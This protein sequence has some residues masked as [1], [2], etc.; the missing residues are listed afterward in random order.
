MHIEKCFYP[1]GQGAFYSETHRTDSGENIVIVYDCGS[2]NLSDLEREIDNFGF[3]KIDYLVI[4]HFHRDHINGIP[5]L[6]KKGIQIK[7]VFIPKLTNSEKALYFIE[8]PE[9]KAVY[10]PEN[11]FGTDQIIEVDNT[12][13]PQEPVDPNGNFSHPLGHATPLVVNKKTDW[14]LKFYVDKA[15]FS[16]LSIKEQAT[17]D[18]FDEKC[19]DD[20]K[21][22]A[23]I[24][25]IYSK[26]SGNFNN[27]SMSM[28]SGPS[29]Y[30]LAIP[31]LAYC[32]RGI[33]LNGDANFSAPGK[34]DKFVQHY[35]DQKNLVS[36]FG[37]PHHGSHHNMRQPLTDFSYTQAVIQSGYLSKHGH[38]AHS[39]IN[40]HES[41]GISVQIITEKSDAW[42][43]PANNPSSN[44]ID[45][46]V[47][48][49]LASKSFAEANF[50]T[51]SL[52]ARVSCLTPNQI[53]GLI[54]N[55]SKNSQVYLSFKL[56][57]LLDALHDEL[58]HTNRELERFM[59]QI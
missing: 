33:L 51:E 44:S 5:S 36:V 1:I 10:N 22:K 41:A 53:R 25:K 20:S 31:F 23:A 29:K 57:G 59:S 28:Y 13:D 52:I 50:L 35:A 56:K 38:P 12:G 40:M 18:A 49:L 55:I 34:I 2:D 17:L 21:K 11:F 26:L 27:T 14:I 32:H 54:Q 58:W 39:I 24:K 8:A 6:L 7:K 47:W 43:A 45:E 30:P 16:K 9:L 42:R 37:I 48:R 4:S 19:I 46:L 15:I 3:R